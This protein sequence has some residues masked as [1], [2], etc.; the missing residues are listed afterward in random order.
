MAKYARDWHASHW[1]G[2]PDT[3]RVAAERAEEALVEASAGEW[4]VNTR[5]V[6]RRGD[7]TI[8][9]WDFDELT[10]HPSDV[11]RITSISVDIG[12]GSHVDEAEAHLRLEKHNLVRPVTVVTAGS[13]RTLV[14]G[15]MQE[16]IE[17]LSREQ[18]W[19]RLV[20]MLYWVTLAVAFASLFAALPLS[21]SLGLGRVN[22]VWETGELVMQSEVPLFFLLATLFLFWVVPS[23]EFIPP[24]G[25]TRLQRFVAAAWAVALSAIG[26]VVYAL[27]RL[28][29]T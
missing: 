13:N 10:M 12:G 16:L 17:I 23:L 8:T 28:L 1:A 4:P 21:H 19:R 2:S 11:A 5:L 25:K 27:F 29:I 3:I 7:L 14:E 24:G 6:L 9:S 26:A 20:G 18:R 22:D 15:L